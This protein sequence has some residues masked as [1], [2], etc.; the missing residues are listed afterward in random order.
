V[1]LDISK[2]FDKVWPEGLISKLK[3]IGIKGTLLKWLQSYLSNRFQR[4]VV[5][6]PSSTW[7]KVNAGVPQAV[8]LDHSWFRYKS[9]ILL[10]IYN[11][12]LFYLLT[13]L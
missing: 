2:A 6:G 12:R 7:E 9:I 13:S 8:F 3:F 1:F 10:M 4:V 5:E 11:L